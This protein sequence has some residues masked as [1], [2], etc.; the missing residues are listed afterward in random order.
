MTFSG[1]ADA[2]GAR[3]LCLPLIWPV[4][5][6]QPA[7]RLAAPEVVDPDLK[8]EPPA[9]QVNAIKLLWRP[10]RVTTGDGGTRAFWERSSAFR[11]I[12]ARGDQSPVY[13]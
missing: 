5:T 9:R 2:K 1:V 10:S 4:R 3:R 11:R 13:R 7:P 8:A 6:D 12:K